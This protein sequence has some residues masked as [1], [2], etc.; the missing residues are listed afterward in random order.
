M[1]DDRVCPS[2]QV[3]LREGTSTCAKCGR[4]VEPEKTG[5][6]FLDFPPKLYS[7]LV[8]RLGPVGARLVAGAVFLILFL[9]WIGWVLIQSMLAQ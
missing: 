7:R 9:I 3:L 6:G 5:L 8:H 4:K 2:C 1:L